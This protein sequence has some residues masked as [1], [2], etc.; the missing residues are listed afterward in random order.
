[1][2]QNPWIP[3]TPTAKQ[4]T[5]LALPVREALFGGAA[6]PGKSSALLMAALQYVD[7][8]G[9][10]ALLLRRTYADLSLPGALM[11]RAEEWLHGKAHWSDKTK[12]WTFRSGATL[13]FGYMETDA[14]RLRY[15]GAEFNSIG[16]DELTQFSEVQYRYLFSRLRRLKGVTIPVRMRAASNPGGIGMEWVSQRFFTEGA[17]RGRWFIPALMGE[18][19]HLDQDE[20]RESLSQ[21]DPT[22]RA[23]LLEGDWTVRPAGGFFD[24]AWFKLGSTP[25]AHATRVRYYDKAGTEGGTGARTA[26]VLM[27]R[28]SDSTFTVEHVIT[29]RWSSMQR[30]AMILQLAQTDNARYPGTVTWVEQEPGSGGKESAENTIRNLAGYTIRAERVTGDKRTRAMPFASAAEAGN[31]NYLSGDWNGDYL[32]E[33]HSFDQGLKDQVDAS[34]GAFNKLAKPARVYTTV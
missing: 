15:Q 6:G 10:A 21:L 33:M 24:R 4:A 31:V 19:P 8:P 18:N 26:G 1:V 7:V 32:D 12:T 22:T 16:F 34:S 29:G 5:F 14:D 17:A 2:L 20:Y 3:Q 23:Q 30:E 11:E 13:T 27:A 25:A 28:N 9:Y